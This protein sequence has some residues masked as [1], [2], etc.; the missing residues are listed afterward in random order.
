M[1]VGNWFVLTEAQK[2]IADQG[3]TGWGAG[4]VAL[5]ARAIDNDT[6]GLGANLNDNAAAYDPLEA[7]TL[8]GGWVV[9]KHMVDDV[10][11]QN[12]A[13]DM[14]VYLLTMPWCMLETETIFAPSTPL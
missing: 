12:Y 5:G 8:T 6:P 7:V 4:E 14:L 13:P 2:I 11:Y 3:G 10:D 1:T 9:P